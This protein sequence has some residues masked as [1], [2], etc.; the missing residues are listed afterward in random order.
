MSRKPIVLTVAALG[1]AAVPVLVPAVSGARRS[2]TAR[3]AGGA[4]MVQSA[5]AGTR[6]AVRHTRLGDLL[7]N[8]RG[9]TVYMFTRDRT[10]RD[11]CARVSGCAGV[12]PLVSTH[13]RPV[14]GPGVRASLLGTIRVG[15]ATQ[16]T[17]AGH[18]LY[19]YSG[20]AS[21]AQTSYVGV[22]Q[23]GGRWFAL[24]ASG[25]QVS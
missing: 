14:A 16:V 5:A 2:P 24:R 13:G 3:A 19:R 7:V 8:G 25:R 4:A 22:T 15:R 20:D 9:F 12:W 10:G 11:V 17:Y 1:S 23:F 21:P 18:P 6:I